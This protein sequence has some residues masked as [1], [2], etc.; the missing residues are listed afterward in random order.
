[1]A[2]VLKVFKIMIYLYE[3]D[4]AFSQHNYSLRKQTKLDIIYV[5]IQWLL[6]FIIRFKL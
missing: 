6:R 1:L 2:I 3:S 5:H 4:G